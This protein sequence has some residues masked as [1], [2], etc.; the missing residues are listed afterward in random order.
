[1]RIISKSRDHF[2]EAR[3]EDYKK[4]LTRIA[5]KAYWVPL[6]SGTLDYLVSSDLA[7][8]PPKDGLPRLYLAHWK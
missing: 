2:H 4:A 6:F 8:T 7:F 5:D 1:M 3:A